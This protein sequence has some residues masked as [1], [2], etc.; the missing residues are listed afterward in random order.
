MTALA[1]LGNRTHLGVEQM[2]LLD[3]LPTKVTLHAWQ[4]MKI[5]AT[6]ELV[7]EHQHASEWWDH[8]A[9]EEGVPTVDSRNERTVSVIVHHSDPRRCRAARPGSAGGD[10]MIGSVLLA[11]LNG[12]AVEQAYRA[13]RYY[14]DASVWGFTEEQARAVVTELADLQTT[15]GCPSDVYAAARERLLWSE[16]PA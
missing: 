6:G 3:Y 14:A 7:N 2:D 13:E 5:R 15:A 10:G 11:T 12:Y 1:Q 4:A 8:E 16:E 9:P